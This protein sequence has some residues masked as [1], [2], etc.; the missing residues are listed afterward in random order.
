ML[1]SCV[2]P[3]AACGKTKS[4]RVLSGLAILLGSSSLFLAGCGANGSLAGIDPV[5]DTQANSIKGTV[6]G[7]QQPVSNATVTLYAAGTTGY[8]SAP[9]SLSTT[10]T[11]ASGSFSLPGFTCPAAPGD[12]VFILATG[13]NPGNSGG[14]VNPNLVQ[15]AALGSCHSSSYPSFVNVDEVTTVASV[16]S[17]AGFLTYNTAGNASA[18]DTPPTSAPA[19]GA[20]PFIG[21]PTS[22]ASC[23]AAGKWTST[24]PSTCNYIG[25]KNAMATVPNLV[26]LGSG[27]VPANYKVP[28]YSIA[29]ITPGNDSYSPS[30]RMNT[31]A[32]IL[33]SC[34]NS[35]G[36][37]ANDGTTNCGTLFGVTTPASTSVS[38]T[39]TLQAFLNLAQAPALSSANNTAFYGLASKNPPFNT[40]APLTAMPNDWAIALGY[41]SGGATNVDPDSGTP[42]P[43]GATQSTILEG[44]AIDQQGNVWATSTADQSS[45]NGGIV[46]ITNQG[47]PISPNTTASTWGAYQTNANFPFADPAIDTAGNIYFGNAGDN[48]FAA[49]N[50]SGASVQ[51]EVAVDTAV[52]GNGFY[53]IG[54]DHSDHVYINGLGNNGAAFAE[55]TGATETWHNYTAGSGTTGSA[56]SGVS[57]AANGNVYFSTAQGDHELNGSTGALVESFGSP[58]EGEEAFDSTGHAYGCVTGQ[59]F[60]DVSSAVTVIN[61]TA[62][63]YG[64]NLF[65]S[66]AIDGNGNL[67]MPV[68][69]TVEASPEGHL[70]EVATVTNSTRG[71]TA[72]ALVS[73]A[74]YGYQGVGVSGSYG[75]SDGENAE[76]LIAEATY[77]IYSIAGTA[78]DGS[79]NVWVLNG[80]GD[81]S[82]A[83][84]VFIEFVGLG[85][86]AVTP[87]ALAAQ[88]SSFAALP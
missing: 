64:S 54:V 83:S 77:S 76:Y 24:G 12:L 46:G 84:Q 27:Q 37:V 86:P 80:Q 56:Y 21:I 15:L 32:N 1:R 45:N 33:S 48:D 87:K 42:I 53:G 62:G 40:P 49:I 14:T 22:G 38:P 13:G 7:G 81:Q 30:G 3:A 58:S 18:I 69:G 9:T 67:W 43:S 74:K 39:D 16:Y 51:S 82:E 29:G 65:G 59:V 25:L 20:I 88:Y 78:V 61:G 28:S 26:N 17:L 19:A 66:I 4:H 23:N 10:T 68:I 85:A 52:D 63:C 79:G 11:N 41:T 44:M 72:G 73:P 36:G 35:T 55:Y 8:G 5:G 6:Y 31:L 57:V 75:G 50:Q 70:N 2:V 47:V 34:V 71:T 60:E